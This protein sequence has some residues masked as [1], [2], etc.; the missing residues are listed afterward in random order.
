MNPADEVAAKIE[1]R[2]AGAVAGTDYKL[3]E[4][5]SLKDFKPTGHP[6]P[7]E[8]LHNLL[9]RISH[10]L[11]YE[12]SERRTNYHYLLRIDDSTKRTIESITKRRASRAFV[13]YIVAICIGVAGTLAWQSY[14]DATKQ[15]IA[16][17]AP[18]LGWS[19]E[20]KQK[21]ANW[22]QQLG[23]T[24]PPAGPESAA[25]PAAQVAPE[26]VVEKVAPKAPAVPPLDAEQVQQMALG[27]AALQQTVEQ[28]A[29]GQDQIAR[30]IA[31]LQAAD[32]EI[33]ERIPTPQPQPPSIP[34]RRP[35]PPPPSSRVTTPPR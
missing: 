21:I 28:I 33:L 16:T 5:A 7:V 10:H 23:W 19:P 8:D 35:I 18:E 27:L 29:G 14:G 4:H 20:A 9:L 3:E 1:T 30:Q 11:D 22:V 34:A 13:R 31:R 17:R 6:R 2:L 24:K 15:I 26:T 32:V 12:T 25:T